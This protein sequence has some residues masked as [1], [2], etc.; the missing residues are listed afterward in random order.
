M[1]DNL[2]KQRFEFKYHLESHTA[3]AVRDFVSSYLELDAF[4]ATQ[5]AYSY[6]VHSLYL[7]SPN[8]K[9]Y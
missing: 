2:Q 9:T 3:L 6:P 4:G 8:L 5:P 7:D 1:T